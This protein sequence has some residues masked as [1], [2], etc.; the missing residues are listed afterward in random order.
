MAVYDGDK[1]RAGPCDYHPLYAQV[2]PNPSISVFGQSGRELWDKNSCTKLN[3]RHQ[4]G[5]GLYTLSDKSNVSGYISRSP[6]F[7][8][9]EE[10]VPGPGAYEY[11]NIHTN[12]VKIPKAKRNLEFPA[13]EG[14]ETVRKKERVEPKSENGGF[15]FTST[16]KR[17]NFE[18]SRLGP[19]LYDQY[20]GDSHS[21]VFSN[22][23][24]FAHKPSAGPGPGH[25]QVSHNESTRFALV[26]LGEKRFR[27]NNH[28]SLP[29]SYDTPCRWEAKSFNMY[30]PYG[31]ETGRDESSSITVGP[32]PCCYNTQVQK[33]RIASKFPQASRFSLAK[34]I[35]SES[36]ASPGSL[37][38]K[39]Y[40][41]SWLSK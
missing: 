4:V 25:Y 24:R 32:G 8:P 16:V 31:V 30:Q 5:P 27:R 19:G 17:S 15:P 21:H 18:S 6:R 29:C 38:K 41:V 26:N 35:S 7:S 28:S 9:R 3:S 13:T 12:S 11:I 10:N 37:L 34:Y 22:S 2:K 40:N 14:K 33:A 23:Q 1:E 39:T 36:F 20:T